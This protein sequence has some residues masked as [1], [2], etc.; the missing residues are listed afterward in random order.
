V[1]QDTTIIGGNGIA[2]SRIG[3]T[4]I[5][6][7]DPTVI[8]GPASANAPTTIDEDNLEDLSYSDEHTETAASGSWDR[9]QSNSKDG[10]KVTIQTGEAYNHVGD[11]T[12]Y[13]FVRDLIFNANGQ[14]VSISTERRAVVD[15]AESC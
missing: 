10:V 13:A 12:L 8:S 1:A 14:L 7:L 9:E 3:D 2:T 15:V 4:W 5:I 6:C 11:K